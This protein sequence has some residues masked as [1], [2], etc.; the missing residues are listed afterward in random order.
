MED[1]LDVKKIR[2]LAANFNSFLNLIS[3]GWYMII[4]FLG[5]GDLLRL[6]LPSPEYSN[7]TFQSL[8]P[9]NYIAN[10][11]SRRKN[12]LCEFRGKI[13]TNRF[14]KHGLRF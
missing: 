13:K 2:K 5:V 3:G 12:I 7:V 14:G 10:S 4:N 8:I 1:Q 11:K 9:F 6:R